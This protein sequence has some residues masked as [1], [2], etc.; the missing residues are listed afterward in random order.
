MVIHIFIELIH[1][2]I[3]GHKVINRM[4]VIIDNLTCM[5]LV[6]KHWRVMLGLAL[7]LDTSELVFT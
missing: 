4:L 5:V 2:S 6:Q 1:K 3:D 7:I